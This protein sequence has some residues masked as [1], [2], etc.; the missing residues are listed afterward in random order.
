MQKTWCQEA[1]WHQANAEEI[2]S[3]EASLVSVVTRL[4]LGVDE[5]LAMSGSGNAAHPLAI[6]GVLTFVESLVVTNARRLRLCYWKRRFGCN[7]NAIATH[8]LKRS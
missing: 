6:A 7:M 2:R 4:S 1:T 3:A 5:V 8:N